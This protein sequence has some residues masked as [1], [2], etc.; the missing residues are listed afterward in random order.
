MNEHK[1]LRVAEVTEMT[2]EIAELLYVSPEVKEKYGDRSKGGPNLYGMMA[3]NPG[4]VRLFKPLSSFFGIHG[5]LPARDREIA[6]LRIAWLNQLPFVWG[7]HVRLGHSQGGLTTE[8]VER[9]TVGSTAAGWSEHDRAILSAVEELK[10]EQDI[11]EDTWTILAQ[12]WSEGQLVELPVLIGT[13]Q[14]L[15]YIQN[16]LRYP[17]WEGNPGMSAR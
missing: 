16:V 2:E 5:K 14:T 13:Y 4:I 7:E 11:A 12:T 1:P 6:I 3:H 8:E 9:I 15:G 17:L 10:F